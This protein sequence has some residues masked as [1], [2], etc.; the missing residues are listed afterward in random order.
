MIT[1]CCSVS[2]SSV[3]PTTKATLN[4]MLE[5]WYNN[6]CN[7]PKS[8]DEF[9]AYAEEH[10]SWKY[11]PIKDSLQ[12]TLSFLKEEKKHIVWLFNYPTVTTMNLTI[13]YY[14]DTIYRKNDQLLFPGLDVSL[15]SYN[16]YHLEYPDSI[17]ELIAYDS[18]SHCLHEG[19]F[20]CCDET[21]E[22]LL[23]NKDKIDWKKREGELL[24]LSGND[25]ITFQ[26]YDSRIQYCDDSII[27]NKMVFRFFDR[28]GRYAHTEELEKTLKT[29]LTQ[30]RENYADTSFEKKE[31]HIIEYTPESGLRPFCHSDNI[32]LNTTWFYDIEDLMYV[33]CCEHDLG[34]VIF[35]SPY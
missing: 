27:S 12:T 7:Y 5:G 19:F 25:T 23:K 26:G 33:F 20:Q 2:H 13:L 22:Y 15:Y 24:V 16:W 31:W 34:R 9:V 8:L 3:S 35:V 28:F 4:I 14:D 10:D 29:R 11:E 1:S 32:Q 21:F 17:E 6:L 30:L 18:L